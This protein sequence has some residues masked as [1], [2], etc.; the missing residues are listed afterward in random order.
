MFGFILKLIMSLQMPQNETRLDLSYLPCLE[1]FS[2]MKKCFYE[3]AL[4]TIDYLEADLDEIRKEEEGGGRG[5][6]GREEEADKENAEGEGGKEKGTTFSNIGRSP[7]IF[8]NDLRPKHPRIRDD[9]FV[10]LD[11]EDEA[12]LDTNEK[13]KRTEDFRA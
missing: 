1:H 10:D 2:E 13:G 4:R 7:I 11:T 9:Y 5:G 8:V 6:D 3:N 12:D